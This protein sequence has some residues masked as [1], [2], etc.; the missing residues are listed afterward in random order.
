MHDKGI[1]NLKMELEL[2]E[3][4]KDQ[5]AI[6]RNHGYTIYKNKLNRKRKIT[7]HL[8]LTALFLL[9]FVTSIRVSPAFAQTIAQIPGF[10]PLVSLITY[11]KGVKDI[12]DNDYYEELGIVQQKNNL[13]L[14]ILGTIA[15]ESGMIVFYQLESPDDISKLET[16]RFRIQ[17]N[18]KYLPASY[19]WSPG[20][21][22]NIIQ[23][24]LEVVSQEPLDYSNPNFELEITF[25]DEHETT[26]EIP[27]T[28][29]K[30]IAPS[31]YFDLNQTVEIDGQKLLVESLK[32]SPLRA[33][34]KVAADPINTMQILNIDHFKLL[35]EHGE[36][37]GRTSNGI[38]G[39]GNFR[40]GTNSIL[41]QSNYF[42]EVEKLTIVMDKIE[43]LPKGEDY[44]EVDFLKQK[45][46]KN[47]LENEVNIQLIGVSSLD[48]TYPEGSSGQL[49]Y[50]AIDAN[51]DEFHYHTNSMTTGINN[52]V[53]SSYYFDLKDAVNPI[54]IF[55]SSYPNYLNGFAKVEI[56][57]NNH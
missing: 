41:I 46:L 22:S 23:N 29:T 51:G 32:I 19:S 50:N 10:A 45:I 27:F 15:D 5:L 48:V 11:D 14:T 54:K 18:N 17:Q 21:K 4:P 53:Q 12:V 49:L 47:P 42:R 9:A 16:K 31:K 24:Q 35:D 43:A 2:I 7:L 26:F 28:L 30:P 37:W 1:E 56:P 3:I 6:A 33:E 52:A 25:L 8:A 34:I 44:I 39:F 57:M 40:E 55:I 20:N 13:T 38:I 36:E